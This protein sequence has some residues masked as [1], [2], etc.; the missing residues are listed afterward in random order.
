MDRRK[1]TNL[2]LKIPWSRRIRDGADAIRTA[3]AFPSAFLDFSAEFCYIFF[4]AY[5]RQRC[6][7]DRTPNEGEIL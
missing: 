7:G 4:K 5:R 6:P 2:T 3:A 1:R